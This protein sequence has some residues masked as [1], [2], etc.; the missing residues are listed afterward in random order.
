MT[1][2]KKPSGSTKYSNPYAPLATLA[3]GAVL[4]KESVCF[5]YPNGDVVIASA[6]PMPS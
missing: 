6:A 4:E 2:M 5:V 3:R 1:T